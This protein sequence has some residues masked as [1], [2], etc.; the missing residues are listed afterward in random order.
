MTEM[1]DTTTDQG[2]YVDDIEKRLIAINQKRAERR[3]QKLLRQGQTLAQNFLERGQHSN[4]NYLGGSVFGSQN[5]MTSSQ[6]SSLNSF[7][8]SIN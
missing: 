3:K 4:S 1:F 2:K 7:N 5:S 6:G 8:R